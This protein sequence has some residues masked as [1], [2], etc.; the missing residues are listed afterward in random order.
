MILYTIEWLQ[1]LLEQPFE[2]LLRLL[3]PVLGERRRRV[4][5]KE[6]TSLEVGA[7]VDESS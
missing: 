7:R 2:E 6:S 3:A 1:A 4:A 5:G